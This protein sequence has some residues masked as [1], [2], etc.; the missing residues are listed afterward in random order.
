M[1]LGLDDAIAQI[2]PPSQMIPAVGQGA[3]GI[4]CRDNDESIIA[5]VRKLDSAETRDCTL[6]ERSL[7]QALQGGCQVP[8][9]AHATLNGEELALDAVIASLDGRDALRR[10]IRGSRSDAVALGKRL[11]TEM[12]SA[13]AD[14]ILAA[15]RG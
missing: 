6:A 14:A 3:L 7:L 13:G 5:L 9:G 12:L 10:S 11:A 2:I 1:R 8:I 4:E 15:V